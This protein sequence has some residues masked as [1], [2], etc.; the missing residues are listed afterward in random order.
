MDRQL[1][2]SYAGRS[3]DWADPRAK[4]RVSGFRHIVKA[5]GEKAPE[6][7]EVAILVDFDNVCHQVEPTAAS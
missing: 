5:M 2:P 3:K 7:K 4:L 1:D 6:A